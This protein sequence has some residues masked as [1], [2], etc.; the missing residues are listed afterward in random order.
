[1]T[2]KEQI[3]EAGVTVTQVAKKMGITNTY[4]SYFLN[5]KPMPL[6]IED[7]LKQVIKLY[8]DL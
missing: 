3:K 4:L 1:M 6:H 8:K 2:Y 7:K 5:G